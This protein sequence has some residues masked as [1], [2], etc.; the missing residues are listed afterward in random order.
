MNYRKYIGSVSLIVVICSAAFGVRQACRAVVAVTSYDVQVDAAFSPSFAQ[1]ITSF[2]RAQT[3]GRLLFMPHLAQVIQEQFPAVETIEITR[4]ACGN[5]E[6]LIKGS[7]P[8]V[9]VNQEKAFTD[10]KL[11]PTFQ[12]SQDWLA[13]RAQVSVSSALCTE[14][15]DPVLAHC[16]AQIDIDLLH[17]YNVTINDIFESWLHDK[18]HHNFS[19]RFNAATLPKNSVVAQCQAIKNELL[20]SGALTKKPQKKW[21]ADV[22]FDNQIVVSSA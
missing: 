2:V 9:V 15:L 17:T 13:G 3:D 19:I 16:L 20:A 8:R 1:T 14:S 11:L 5:V 18:Q 7:S 21:I 10:G 12:F 4:N 22:R 6:V